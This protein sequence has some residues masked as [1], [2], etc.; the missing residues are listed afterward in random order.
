MS[1]RP[2]SKAVARKQHYKLTVH[3]LEARRKREE[4]MVQIRKCRREETLVKKRRQ[5]VASTS[6]IQLS[7]GYDQMISLYY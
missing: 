6:N 4:N 3:I 7:S 2:N 1:L 5:S